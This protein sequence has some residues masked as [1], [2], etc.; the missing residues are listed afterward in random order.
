MCESVKY[1]F[2]KIAAMSEITNIFLTWFFFYQFFKVFVAVCFWVYLNVVHSSKVRQNLR[3]TCLV[4]FKIWYNNTFGF[5][6]FW[7]HE[8][9]IKFCSNFPN[10]D[11]NFNS[12]FH[13]TL[14]SI[15]FIQIHHQSSQCWQSSKSYKSFQDYCN[16]GWLGKDLPWKFTM[17]GS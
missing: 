12:Q 4:L 17:E 15:F 11:Q 7:F 16:H 5:L 13:K 2:Q 10:R 1:M 8:N 3:Q 6:S 9:Q 14:A